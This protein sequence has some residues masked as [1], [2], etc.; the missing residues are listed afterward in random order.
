M[1]NFREEDGNCQPSGQ[2]SVLVRQQSVDSREVQHL[3]KPHSSASRLNNNL[4]VAARHQYSRQFP[5]TTIILG[6]K[7]KTY[8]SRAPGVQC[9]QYFYNEIV[10]FY[11]HERRT[12]RAALVAHFCWTG[13]SIQRNERMRTVRLFSLMKQEE[14]SL[15]VVQK[16]KNMS[17]SQGETRDIGVVKIRTNNGREEKRPARLLIDINGKNPT[18]F[19][20]GF[21]LN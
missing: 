1:I 5:T 9:T 11:V 15:A 19:H 3:R 18:Q 21:L 20:F 13:S 6:T 14:N 2:P 16:T 7:R 10:Y 4:T 17:D 8:T 12:K